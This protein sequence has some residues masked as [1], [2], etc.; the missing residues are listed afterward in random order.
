MSVDYA[1]GRMVV[2]NAGTSDIMVGMATLQMSELECAM[3]VPQWWADYYQV[4]ITTGP[5]ISR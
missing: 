3:R 4:N 5:P 2:M 1:R